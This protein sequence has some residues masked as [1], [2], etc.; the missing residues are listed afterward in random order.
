MNRQLREFFDQQ[1]ELVVADLPASIQA[2]LD[3]APLMVEDHPSEAILRQMGVQDRSHLCGLFSGIPLSRQSVE[4]PFQLPNYIFI[5]REGICRLSG[6]RA[7]HQNTVELR[8]Q[9]RITVLHEI[10][11]HFGL[12][13]DDLA[14]LGYG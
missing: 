8:R 1:M 14:E 3:E 13:E 5:Y 6:C 7:P 4:I 12:T 2:L 9:I 10:G 11:H